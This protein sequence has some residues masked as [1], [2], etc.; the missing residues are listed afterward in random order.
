MHRTINRFWK[1]FKNLPVAVQKVS[2][3][4]FE[5]LKTNPLHPSLHF[6]KIGKFW[7][8]RAGI[9]HRALA[10]EDGN[11]FIWVWIGT[12]EEYER[13]IKVMG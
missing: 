5:L 8:V 13:M 3:K 10:V 7:S 11:D 6:K 4:N 9:N 2:K 12:H 1:C